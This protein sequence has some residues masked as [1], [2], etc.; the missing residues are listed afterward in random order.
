MMNYMDKGR[1]LDRRRHPLLFYKG[2]IK[3]IIFFVFIY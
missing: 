2:A 3:G 1:A